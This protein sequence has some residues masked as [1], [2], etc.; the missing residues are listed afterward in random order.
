MIYVFLILFVIISF[1]S[2]LLYTKIKLETKHIVYP[3]RKRYIEYYCINLP[4][5][6]GKY[7]HMKKM[8]LKES[9]QLNFFN[10]INGKE[11]SVESY[12]SDFLTPTY[13][14]YLQTNPKQKG[15]LGATFSHL[16]M[17]QLIVDERLGQTVVF[18]DD[19]VIHKGFSNELFDCLERMELVDPDWDI[20]QLGFSCSY[21]S[22]YKC[23]QNDDV[24]IRA[25][26]IIRLGYAIGLFG[27]VINGEKGATNLLKHMFPVSWHIDHHIQNLNN[28][29]KIK[30]YATIPNIVFHPGKTEISSF[31]EVYQ[32]SYKSY[33]SDTNFKSNQSS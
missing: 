6:R 21:D 33:L 2:V 28:K 9:I 23:H 1:I 32:T 29:G 12:H 30:A 19:C 7:E 14:L 26:K 17:L 10:G 15:H 11:L 27:Y 13:K 18:E 31:N 8:L 25:G 20:L 5:R 24:T 4:F 3:N 16:S 22:Y